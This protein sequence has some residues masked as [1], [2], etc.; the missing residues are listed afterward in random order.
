LVGLLL[1][2]FTPNILILTVGVFLTLA[3]IENA[4]QYTY[5]YASE[6]ISEKHRILFIN[7]L[8][9]AYG[10]GIMMNSFSFYWLKNWKSVLLFFFIIPTI[11]IIAMIMYYI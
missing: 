3:G 6:V 9:A 5:C 1:V 8:T 7:L 11:V 2:F 10:V 4:Y